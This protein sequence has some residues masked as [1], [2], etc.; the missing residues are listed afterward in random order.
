M[1]GNKLALIDFD[2]IITTK[3]TF[4]SF[5]RFQVGPIMYFLNILRL[6]PWIILYYLRLSND[7][8]LKE[9]VVTLFLKGTNRYDLDKLITRYYKIHNEKLIHPTAMQKIRLLRVKGYRM[10]VVS[11]NIEPLVKNFCQQFNLEWI[12]TPLE[13]NN[14]LITG[15]LL[16]RNCK[17]KEKVNRIKAYVNLDNY[18]YIVAWGDRKSDRYMLDLANMSTLG[19]FTD[20]HGDEVLI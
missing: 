18:S 14:N 12:A 6:S 10:I 4:L 8:L 1:N 9:K 3:D 19:K 11:A 7:D 5:L 2:G 13:H 15:K 16:S 17:G 20:K